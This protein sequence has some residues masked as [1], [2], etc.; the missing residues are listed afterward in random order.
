MGNV[1]SIGFDNFKTLSEEKRV[2][3]FNGPN[4]YDFCFLSEGIIIKTTL[5]K[6]AIENEKAF[7]S[8]SLFYNSMELKFRIP[9]P[10]VNIANVDT[11][12]VPMNIVDIQDEEVKNTDIQNEGVD[13]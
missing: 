2:Y 10:S 4:F 8:D 7:F 13:E 3:Y 9:N 12:K 5:M 1:I 6:T 11:P